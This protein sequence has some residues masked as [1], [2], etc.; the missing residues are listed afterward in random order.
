MAKVAYE[1]QNPIEFEGKQTGQV[2]RT[3]SKVE[4]KRPGAKVFVE[5][6]RDG[7]LVDGRDLGMSWALVR[8]C[9]CGN[10]KDLDDLSLADLEGAMK[11]MEDEGFFGSMSAPRPTGKQ[12]PKDD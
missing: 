11:A 7:L 3:I 2:M 6:E 4:F 8:S 1:L 9:Y 5:L 12:A 10:A